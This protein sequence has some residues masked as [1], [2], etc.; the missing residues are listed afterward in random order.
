[1]IS[2]NKA[3]LIRSLEHKKYRKELGLFVAEGPKVV[4]DLLKAKWKPRV[5]VSTPEGL[6]TLDKRNICWNIEGCELIDA[7]PEDLRKVSFLQHP[8]DMIGVFYCPQYTSREEEG[9]DQASAPSPFTK[10][11]DLVLALDGVQDPGNLGTIIRIADWFGIETIYCSP[12]SADAFNPKVVQATMGSLARVHIIYKDIALF[13]DELPD[14]IPVYGTVLDGDNIYEK[15]LQPRGVIV[16]GNEG[17]G[18]SERVRQRLTHR[19]LIPSFPPE[20]PTA[21]SLNVAVATAIVCA[22]FRR[23]K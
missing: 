13:I 21:E 7:T 20:R 5:L 6:L 23:Y 9:I 12:D 2:K 15:D 22:E 11:N 16:M 19:L 14:D 8:Q 1:M 17:N 10:G 3:K 18:I 4:G